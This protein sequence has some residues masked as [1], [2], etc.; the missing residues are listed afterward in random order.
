MG[1][2]CPAPQLPR[3]WRLVLLSKVVY[4]GAPGEGPNRPVHARELAAFL[5][6]LELRRPTLKVEFMPIYV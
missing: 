2:L 4:G 1:L 6:R 3:L 5:G